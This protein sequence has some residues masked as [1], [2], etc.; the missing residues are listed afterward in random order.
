MIPSLA[1]KSEPRPS[2]YAGVTELTSRLLSPPD[3]S[4]TTIENRTPPGGHDSCFPPICFWCYRK[5]N[6]TISLRY[7]LLKIGHAFIHPGLTY[8]TYNI[9]RPPLRGFFYVHQPKEVPNSFPEFSSTGENRLKSTMKPWPRRCWGA[10]TKGGVE[11]EW[12]RFSAYYIFSSN[13]EPCPRVPSTHGVLKYG[14]R[15]YSQYME[16]RAEISLSIRGQ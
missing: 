15:A 6:V 9:R 11:G 14:R 5:A 10:E 7:Y 1:P 16:V 12:C 3:K 13:C 2:R 8:S 4:T